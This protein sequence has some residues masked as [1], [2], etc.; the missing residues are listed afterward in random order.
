MDRMNS[1]PMTGEP[2]IHFSFFVNWYLK[3]RSKNNNRHIVFFTLFY[4]ILLFYLFTFLIE[5]NLS[6]FVDCFMK[7]S[8]QSSEQI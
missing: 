5:V 8:L 3:H 4:F 7:I 1:K 2:L 6:A